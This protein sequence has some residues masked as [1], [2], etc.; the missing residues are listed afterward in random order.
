MDKKPFFQ[1][2]FKENF[3]FSKIL[4]IFKSNQNK[5]RYF[6]RNVDLFGYMGKK[7]EFLSVL[8]TEI[9][10]SSDILLFQNDLEIT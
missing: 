10:I 3:I 4:D 9:L 5:K 2:Q 7:D 8:F 1:R 6:S